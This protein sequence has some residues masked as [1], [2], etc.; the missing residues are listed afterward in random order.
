M[1]PNTRQH[2]PSSD[3]Q[4]DERAA[5]AAEPHT[6]GTSSHT[7][8]ESHNN[9][10]NMKEEKESKNSADVSGHEATMDG[11]DVEQAGTL[12][13]SEDGPGDEDVDAADA[14]EPQHSIHGTK[15][16]A[17]NSDAPPEKSARRSPQSDGK[18]A[19]TNPS[20]HLSS[21]DQVKLLNFLLSPSSLTFAR[22]Q[23]EVEDLK[24][25]PNGGTMTR[26]YG[27]SPFTPFEELLSALILSRPI[28]HMLGVRSIRTL[29]NPPH[30][31]VSPKLIRETGTEGVGQALDDARTQHRQKTAEEIVLLA[32]AVS[33][34][35]GEDHYDV[36]LEKVREECEH[37]M[38]K[39]RS[40]LQK[41]IK[42]MGPTGLDIFGRRIQG[43]WGEW[44][45]F[46]DQ[47]TLDALGQLGLPTNA[48]QLKNVLDEHWKELVV[49]GVIGDDEERRR[50]AF[51]RVLERAIGADLEGK[52]D[53]MRAEAMK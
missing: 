13:E 39:E 44:Y 23:D 14:A 48:D 4:A 9:V 51:V 5:T 3:A 25:R 26:T 40:I 24:K 33:D 30:N 52:L 16:K 37:N 22:P 34:T 2:D 45:P 8:R 35:L 10:D 21:V 41:T 18:S 49:D 27:S 36:S 17:S 32:D 47:K 29:L 53:D 7:A 15:R 43:S 20:S 31:L 28:G 38:D 42:G 50:R 19:K 11:E 6:N 1:A 12:Q 46:A